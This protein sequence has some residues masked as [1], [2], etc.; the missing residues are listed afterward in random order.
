ML[1][2]R[3]SIRKNFLRVL[4]LGAFSLVPTSA[5]VFAASADADFAKRCAEP[6]VIKCVGFDAAGD[7]A[8]RWGNNS[9]I[10]SGASTPTL[11]ASVK[12]SGGSALKFTIPSNSWGDTSGTYFTNFSSDLS[13][14]FGENSE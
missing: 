1:H 9:G 7:I 14:Q 12:A 10:T 11:D 4:I 13:T 3:F 5:H 6:G 8:G 2:S